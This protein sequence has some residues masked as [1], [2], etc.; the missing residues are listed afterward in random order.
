MDE[1]TAHANRV[2]SEVWNNLQAV[3]N[4][5]LV[6]EARANPKAHKTC[7]V[8]EPGKSTRYFYY[9]DKKVLK[10]QIVRWCYSKHRNAAGYYL[11]FIEIRR[12]RHGARTCFQGWKSKKDAIEHC[13]D[14]MKDAEKPKELRK[15]TIPT[16]KKAVSH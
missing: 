11:S 8:M 2:L 9:E 7:L 6:E 10:N 5:Q 4:R 16:Y 3:S 15:F 1:F 13:R 14:R 12:G